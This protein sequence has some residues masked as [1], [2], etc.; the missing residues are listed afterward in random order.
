MFGRTV[1]SMQAGGAD[2]GLAKAVEEGT[3][4]GPRILFCGKALSQSGGHG[5]MR[6]RAHAFVSVCLLSL[7]IRFSSSFC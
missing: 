1:P 2:F 4:R 3:I 7:S 5:D 6:S